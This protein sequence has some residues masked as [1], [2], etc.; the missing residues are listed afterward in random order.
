MKPIKVICLIIIFVISFFYN[1]IYVKADNQKESFIENKEY[2]V[3]FFSA[4][5]AVDSSGNQYISDYITHVVQMYDKDGKYVHTIVIKDDG[6]FYIE[7]DKDD[8]LVVA[9][10]RSERLVTYNSDGYIVNKKLTDSF[11][12]AEH[13]FK[14][15]YV[16]SSVNGAK[17][18]LENIMGYIT[19]L[20]Q[21]GNNFATTYIIPLG[22]WILKMIIVLLM[23][24]ILISVLYICLRKIKK[25][26]DLKLGINRDK[27]FKFRDYYS[28]VLFRKMASGYKNKFG[29]H[30]IEKEFNKKEIIRNILIWSVLLALLI[31]NI[32]YLIL[33]GGFFDRGFE[34]VVR[35]ISAFLAYIA[36]DIIIIIIRY[37]K[38]IFMNVEN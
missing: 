16:Y 28:W 27:P 26:K 11:Y 6:G 25:D 3:W 30:Y 9:L 18:H 38:S 35:L 15:R 4:S 5:I 31:Y 8:N 13:F 34:P 17:Y 1:M 22:M 33:T 2:P 37:N 24:A 19:V 7:I 29:D 23:I 20:K 21:E 12:I 36:L 10:E 32:V 14:S